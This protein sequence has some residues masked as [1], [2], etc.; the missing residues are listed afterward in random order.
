MN[1]KPCTI[2]GI[3]HKYVYITQVNN[4]LEGEYRDCIKSRR[5]KIGIT[6]HIMHQVMS[7][8]SSIATAQ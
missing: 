4:N 8:S 3:M 1:E 6:R 7:P 5:D 2:L